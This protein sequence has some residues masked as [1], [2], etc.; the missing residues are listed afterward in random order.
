M[1]HHDLVALRKKLPSCVT[2]LGR[3]VGLGWGPGA[4]TLRTAALFPIG[5]PWCCVSMGY[6]A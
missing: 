6:R 5:E 4:K 1:F 2:L 3:L